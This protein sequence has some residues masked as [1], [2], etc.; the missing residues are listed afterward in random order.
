MRRFWQ[1]RL[2]GASKVKVR[3]GEGSRGVAGMERFVLV[4]LVWL[5]YVAVCFIL[6]VK[7]ECEWF[8]NGKAKSVTRSK[9]RR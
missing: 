9:Q 7:G 1:A 3:L 6:F 8:T 5:R 2:G 4:S